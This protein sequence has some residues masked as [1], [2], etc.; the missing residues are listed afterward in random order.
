MNPVTAPA[1][2]QITPEVFNHMVELAALELTGDEAEYLRQQLNNQLRA[3]EELAQIPLPEDTPLAAHG[4]SY[5]RE[6]AQ[7]LRPDLWQPYPD[8]RDIL[9]QTPQLE[10]GYIIVP[11]IPHQELD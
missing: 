7:P 11:E 4:V 5:P 8:V 3:I 6:R 9:A 2:E 1:G 10:D